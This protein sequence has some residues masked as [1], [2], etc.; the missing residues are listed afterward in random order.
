MLQSLWQRND[1]TTPQ[2][3]NA[4]NTSLPRSTASLL[5]VVRLIL[6]TQT[7]LAACF[8]LM[9]IYFQYL[10]LTSLSFPSLNGTLGSESLQVSAPSNDHLRKDVR[11][12]Q[13]MLRVSWKL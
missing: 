13:T 11:N 9:S 6:P 10:L 8:F 4:L 5:D 3:S 7:C 1:L 2:R 12:S